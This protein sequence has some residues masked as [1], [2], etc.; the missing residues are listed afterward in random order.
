MSKAK[1]KKQ[2]SRAAPVRRDAQGRA[3]LIIQRDEYGT[4]L[5]VALD[6]PLFQ[7]QWQNELA[8][9]TAATTNQMLNQAYTPEQAAALG[10]NAMVGTSTMADGLIA[11]SPN[12][13]PA[14]RAGCAHC[15]HQTV[16]VTAPE[17][18]AIHAHLRATRTPDELDAVAGRIRAA[19]DRTRGMASLDRVSPDLP[20]PFLVDERCSIYEARPLACR[21]TN[22]L[23]ASA[24]ERSLHDPATR[25]AFLAGTVSVPC[26]LEPMRAFHAVTAGLQLALDQLHGLEVTPLE[27]T[28]AMRIMIDDPDTVP[29]QWLGGK[30]PFAAARGGDNTH[31]PRN[32]KLSGL[33]E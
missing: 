29:E 27:L 30:D 9:A 7:E 19:D 16:G 4:P 2:K 8:L 13:P 10:R 17:V 28:A 24:C 32:R 33:A 6:G 14:C 20:C 21:G 25:A 12:P 5:G 11:Q 1:G 15:C 3:H 23:D 31:D 22:S 18:F 26:Y